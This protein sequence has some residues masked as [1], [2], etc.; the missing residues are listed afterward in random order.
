MSLGR[1]FAVICT[2]LFRSGNPSVQTH[3]SQALSITNL[4]KIVSRKELFRYTNGRFF[5]NET[6]ACNQRYVRFDVGQLCAVAAI[7][8]KTSSPIRAIDKMEGSFS[9]VLTMQE[10]DGNEVVAKTP[11]PTQG[12]PKYTIASEVAIL[13]F[14]ETAQHYSFQSDTVKTHTRLAVSKS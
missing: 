4:G 5:V 9:K 6:K 11:L 12:P 1:S 2:E 14:S 7:V 3:A 13:K 8:G 10:E